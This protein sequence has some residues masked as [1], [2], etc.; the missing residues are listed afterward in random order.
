MESK[1]NTSYPTR[2]LTNGP[3]HH[4]F[5]FHDLCPWS[6]DR[7]YVISLQ[8]NF[9]DRPPVYSDKAVVGVIDLNEDCKF[10]EI[11]TTNAWNF[12]QGARQQWFPKNEREIIYN[13]LLNDR[14]C[15]IKINIETLEKEIFECPIYA[16]HP[17]GEYGLG[18]NFERLYET[19]GYGYDS[20]KKNTS[21][22]N[23]PDND[24][25]FRIDF[26]T[27]EKKLVISISDVAKTGNYDISKTKNHFL[28]HITFNPNGSRIAFCHRYWAED[29]GSPIRL[30]TSNTDGTDLHIFPITVT[31]FNWLNSNRI[32]AFGRNRPWISKI[33]SHNV[34]S[35]PIFRQLLTLIRK[36]RSHV[37]QQLVGDRYFLLTDKEKITESIGIGILADD[38]HPMPS[39]NER[40][41]VTD[42]YA[43]S[44][45]YRQL[46]VYDLNKKAKHIIGNYYSLPSKENF[47]E[48]NWDESAMRSDLHPRWN[49]EGTQICIDSVHEGTRQIYIVDV[50][51]LVSI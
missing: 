1:N 10:K 24:G 17:N 7:R 27:G 34:F 40:F 20:Q 50:E 22:V 16:I 11:A 38:G 30:C 2:R 33:R 31:H 37:R 46:I 36:T 41:F 29:G 13:D 25:I 19:G 21:F 4:F 42:T 23:I 15:S 18:I 51:D 8:T 48:L 35:L 44:E 26:S 9:I 43:D 3:K 5:G 28:S 12:Q 45:H 47:K 39:P 14:F 6:S 49:K 32:L